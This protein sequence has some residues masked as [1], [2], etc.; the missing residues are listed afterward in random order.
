MDNSSARDYIYS[1]VCGLLSKVYTGSNS[2]KIL[3]VKTLAELYGLL[4]AK[5]VP[6]VPESILAGM[7]ENEAEKRFLDEFV[8]LLDSFQKPDR[9]LVELL[10]FYDYENLK[11]IAGAL[12]M[13]EEK[14]PLLADIGHYSMLNYSKWPDIAAVTENSPLSWYNKIPEI[15]E[16]QSLD[17]RLDSQYMNSIWNCAKKAGGAVGESV[18]KLF[19]K[20]F[21][22][23]NII[24][25]MRLRVYY[26]MSVEEIREHLFFDDRSKGSKDVLA[27]PALKMLS[28]DFSNYDEWKDWK[29][30][31]MLNPNTDGVLWEVDPRWVENAMKTEISRKLFSV[32]HQHSFTVVELICYFKIKQDEL[33]LIRCV[34]ESLRLDGSAQ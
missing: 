16:Q 3:S 8:E 2:Q 10:R 13:H 14:E 23:D 15:G 4:F 18:V 33:D 6:V 5:E 9:I 34:T 28:R 7:I 31:K 25:A 24:W 12:C 20:E 32:F 1:K 27:G 26:K 22:F 17:S 21:V 30:V 29:Y 11:E 19:E